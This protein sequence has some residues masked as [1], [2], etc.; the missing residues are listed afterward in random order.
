MIAAALAFA[1]G[2]APQATPEPSDGLVRVHIVVSEPGGQAVETLRTEDFELLED[3]LPRRI[4]SVRFVRPGSGADPSATIGR[5]LPEIRSRADEESEAAREGS[6]LFAFLLDEYHVTPGP[7]AARARDALTRFVA[8]HVGPHDLVVVLKPLDSL[9]TIRLSRPGPT[10]AESIATF[11]GRKGV[12]EPRNAFE[13]DFMAANPQRIDGVRARISASALNALVAHLGR[14]AAGRKT[15]IVVSEGFAEVDRGRGETMP[16]LEGIVESARRTGV[17]IYPV[18]PRMEAGATAGSGGALRRLADATAG[19]VLG[20][21]GDIDAGFDEINREQGGYYVLTFESAAKADG[22][23]HPV[24]VRALRPELRVSG[25]QGHWTAPPAD[26]AGTGQAPWRQAPWGPPR[27]TSSLIR[28]WF[29]VARGSDGLS[30]V[31]F[32]WEPAPA[33]TRPAR[34]PTPARVALSVS[35]SDGTRVFE[36][37]VTPA[38][39]GSASDAHAV[40]EVPPGRLLVEMSIEGLSAEPIDTDVRDVPVGRLTDPMAMGSAVVFRARN[41]REFR[42]LEA[43]LEAVPVASREFRRSERLLIR[44]PAYASQG[45]PEVTARLVSVLGAAMRDLAVQRGPA[46]DLY[47]ID[48]PLAGL[49]AGEY[50]VELAARGLGIAATEVVAFRV[51]P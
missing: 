32:V 23:F 19:R 21:S 7:A 49:V 43:N 10:L 39:P 27:R 20:G 34:T 40:F 51:T 26:L 1:A 5:P 14:L 15:L 22:A 38:T 8:R 48:L 2:L 13:K 12:Y 47:Q 16:S 25:S 46:A 35:T 24:T 4:H 3:G 33:V 28:S 6:R 44:V 45:A 42:A 41:A 29:G 17:A 50:R 31:S 18:E 11:E 36:G 9:L 30:R 37:V